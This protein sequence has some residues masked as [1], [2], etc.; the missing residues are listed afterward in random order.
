MNRLRWIAASAIALAASPIAAA[1]ASQFSPQRLS[2]IDK[3]LS[4]DA[5]QGRGTGAAIEPTVIDR[6]FTRLGDGT[7]MRVVTFRA[8]PQH[9]TTDAPAAASTFTLRLRTAAA[10]AAA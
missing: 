1:P 10:G 9:E 4:S 8:R 3:T 2:E 5:F 6:R 7:R